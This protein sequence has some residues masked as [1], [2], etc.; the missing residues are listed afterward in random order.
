MRL[1][2]YRERLH[3]S[4]HHDLSR[5]D[6]G[7]TVDDLVATLQGAGFAVGSVE[8]VRRTVLDTFD[9]RSRRRRPPP[10]T[11]QCR[12]RTS[13]RRRARAPRRRRRERT[14]HGRGGAAPVPTTSRPDRC[15]SGS[16]SCSTSASSCHCSSCR[17]SGPSRRNETA[18]ARRPR[19]RGSTTARLPAI[20]TIA[21]FVVDVVELAGY[22]KPAADLRELVEDAGLREVSTGGLVELAAAATGLRCQVAQSPPACRSTR[23]AGT[24]RVPACPRQPPRCDRR[25]LGRHDRRHRRRVPARAARRRPTHPLRAR[26]SARACCPTT[27]A[28]GTARSSAG[29]A[30]SPGPARDLDVYLLGWDDYVGARSPRTTAAASTG[31]R[32]SSTGQR[33]A[34]HAE[35]ADAARRRRA[36]RTARRAGAAGSTR[37]SRRRRPDDAP[38][39]DRRRSSPSASRRAHKTMLDRRPGDHARHRRRA[40]C[41]TCARTP[42]SCATCSSASAA[43]SPP[44]PRKAFVAQLKALQDNLGEHQDAE[45][46]LAQLRDLAHDLHARPTSTPTTLLAIGQLSDQLDAP[47]ARDRAEFAERF[48]ALRH[49]RPTRR[50]AAGRSLARAPAATREGR[51]HLQHQGR[52]REDHRGGEP[53]PSRPPRAG[54]RVLVWDL[55]PQGAATFFFRVKPEGARAAADASSAAKGELGRAHPRHR[56]ARPARRCPPTSRC[57]TST[58]TSRARA[59]STRAARRRCSSRSPTTTTSPCSTARPASRWPARACSAPPTRCS[60]RPSRHAVRRTLGQLADFLATDDAPPAVLPFLSM[61]DRRKAL[62]RDLLERLEH[63]QP[64]FLQAAIP[65]ASAVERMG[66]QRAPLGEFAARTAAA[67][68]FHDLWTEIA[69]YLWP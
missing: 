45:V 48:A 19:P 7:V 12:H 38:P 56:P 68:A 50:R 42:R 27:S 9:G 44:A 24:R 35:L 69:T 46:H 59:H 8:P 66:L 51:R 10:R 64:R 30:R 21:P 49:R 41:T 53:R 63:G 34:A 28:T 6:A 1:P 16:P 3:G 4:R 20:T 47:P 14:G 57:A 5:P 15:G 33:R 31:A 26:P 36:G 13:G 39:A 55:D 2:H 11:H 67:Q 37:R 29:S 32:L 43:C 25:Q 23:P 52:R 61:V 22:P 40:R 54:A 18:P 65:N 58:S 60:C 62:H 17:P